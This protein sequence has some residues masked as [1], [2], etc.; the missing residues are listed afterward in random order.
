MNFTNQLNNLNPFAIATS[1]ILQEFS[2]NPLINNLQVIDFTSQIDIKKDGLYPA[3]F[4]LP[5]GVGDVGNMIEFNYEIAIL[6]SRI[7]DSNF[8]QNINTCSSAYISF[9]N[10]LQLLQNE[11][12]IEIVGQPR[13]SVIA[14]SKFNKLDGV[15]IQITLAVP[16]NIGVCED[17]SSV[18]DYIYFTADN[19]V[20]SVDNVVYTIDRII[21]SNDEE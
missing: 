6:T 17:D 2:K 5:T 11:L 20:I 14:D 10:G 12:N 3:V 4:V 18:I 19:I 9:I 1:C 21:M 7:D 8:V 16:N 13:A 15:T